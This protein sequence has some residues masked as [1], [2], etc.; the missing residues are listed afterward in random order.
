MRTPEEITA[1][2]AALKNLKPVGFHARRTADSIS[3]QV[4]ELEYGFDQ[5]SGEWAELTYT[6]RDTI[7]QA[8]EWK[9]GN[10]NVRPSLECGGLCD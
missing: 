2:I 10:S 6:E 1:E 7:N 5:T 9:Q 4:E 3:L 8:F